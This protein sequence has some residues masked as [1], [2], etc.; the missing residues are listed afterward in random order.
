MSFVLDALAAYV[1]DRTSNVADSLSRGPTAFVS[2]RAV[3][4]PPTVRG[5]QG[6]RTVTE[7]TTLGNEPRVLLYGDAGAG[8]TTLVNFVAHHM[9]RAFLADH[10]GPCP[11]LVA[12]RTL[13]LSSGGAWEQLVAAG[14]PHRDDDA[15]CNGIVAA[16]KDGRLYLFVDGFDELTDYTRRRQ[17]ASLL[18]AVLVEQPRLGML[19]SSR[20]VAGPDSLTNFLASWTLLPF[21]R[22]QAHALLSRLTNVQAGTAFSE[23][24]GQP[25]LSSLTTTPLYLRLLASYIMIQGSEVP[26]SQARVFEDLTVALWA[27]E[28]ARLVGSAKSLPIE[29][30]QRGMELVAV[31]LTFAGTATASTAM[32]EHILNEDAYGLFDSAYTNTFL[33][34]ALERMVLLVEHGPDALGFEYRSFQEFYLGRALARDIAMLDRLP[35]TDLSEPLLFAAG[36]ALD[37]VAVVLAA[38]RRYG[39]L[40]AARCCEQPQQQR[41]PAQ[42][43]LLRA[44]LDDLGPELQEPLRRLL[45]AAAETPPEI[46]EDEA[47]DIFSELSELWAK[48]PR[49]EA[50][51]DARG[52]GLE[53]FAVTLFGSFFEV[54]TVRRRHQVGEVDVICENHNLDPF[55]MP[56]GGDVWIECKNTSTK[57]SLEQV[58]VFLGKLSGTRHRLGFFLSTSGFTKDAMAR[59]RQ[60]GSSANSSL[61]APISGEDVEVLLARRMEFQRFFKDRIRLVA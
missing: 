37:P 48:L 43:A 19:V 56:F 8:K 58:N 49:E 27:Y 44:L 29:M 21:S 32:L 9:A 11:L 34:Y 25:M 52:R 42:E 18:E 14:W 5:P 50:S 2:Q 31:A 61:V 41:Q 16:A 30:F 1:L 4:V 3:F 46:A 13:P 10:S 35:G 39:V 12:A 54:V 60:A 40:L 22:D 23:M 28:R 57:T 6:E 53:Q 45:P 24:L 36:L 7:W 38:Y 55:W 20:P 17:V 15:A 51:A 26:R 59:L 33:S 47:D